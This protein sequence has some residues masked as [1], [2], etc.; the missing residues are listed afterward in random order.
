MENS[1][2]DETD[3]NYE[4]TDARVPWLE[5]VGNLIDRGI[6]TWDPAGLILSCPEDE[7]FFIEQ[8][9]AIS[10]RPLKH[11]ILSFKKNMANYLFRKLPS[12]TKRLRYSN[13]IYNRT[14]RF[15]EQKMARL[16]QIVKN[17]MK[18]Q[19]DAKKQRTEEKRL[20]MESNSPMFPAK[21][22]KLYNSTDPENKMTQAELLMNFHNNNDNNNNLNSTNLLPGQ[23]NCLRSTDFENKYKIENQNNSA[24]AQLPTFHTTSR[25][26]LYTS[27]NFQQ[28]TPQN[29]NNNSNT[30]AL[31]KSIKE[32]SSS[33]NSQQLMMQMMQMMT[34]MM[35]NNNDPKVSSDDKNSQLQQNNLLMPET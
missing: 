26:Q 19:N 2:E 24:A 9:H 30:E 17:R 21:K 31:L 12:D 32:N 4:N 15:D 3:S 6:L 25:P 13:E 23:V 8:L 27:S 33:D 22:P 28:I 5:T 7:A 29:N 18:L 14:S 10:A 11:P 34:Q 35:I 20:R 16:T 1:R